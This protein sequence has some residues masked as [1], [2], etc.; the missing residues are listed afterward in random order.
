MVNSS[1]DGS[2]SARLALSAL[3]DGDASDRGAA[4]VGAWRDDADAR[5][6]WHAYHLIGDV[7][8]S[9]D[10]AV[11]PTHDE[12][13]LQAL[14]GRL[15]VE[16]V[17][18]A[19]APLSEPGRSGADADDGLAAPVASS[20]AA[21]RR[22]VSWLIAPAAVAAGFVTV[23]GVLV[24]TRAWSPGVADGGVMAQAGASAPLAATALVASTDVVRNARLNRYLEAH[25]ALSNGVAAA[26]G[27]EHRV[28]I[29]FESK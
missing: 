9:D 12:G 29:V 11:A 1:S 4:A 5:A 22:A 17:P 21:R 19:P 7:L 23:A 28:Q 27:A 6:S 3:M 18:L 26:S 8:R 20:G 2:S 10:L 24:V 13:F 14:R 16:P 25:R 15:A